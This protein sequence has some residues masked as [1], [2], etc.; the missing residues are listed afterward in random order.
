MGVRCDGAGFGGAAVSAPDVPAFPH[1]FNAAF[2]G[3]GVEKFSG[4]SLR[5]YFAAAALNGFVSR[6]P[7][8]A[9]ASARWAYQIA[10]EMLK[11]RVE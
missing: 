3:N 5:D 1:C 4:M 8:T 10:D 11:V 2:A 6:T 7:A 9:E